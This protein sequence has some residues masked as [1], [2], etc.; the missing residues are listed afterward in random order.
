ME[1]EVPVRFLDGD[2]LRRAQERHMD[3][4]SEIIIGRRENCESR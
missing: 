3:I 1:L 4:N 2:V